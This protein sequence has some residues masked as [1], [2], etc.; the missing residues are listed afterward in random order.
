M[1][2]VADMSVGLNLTYQSQVSLSLANANVQ[3]T[4]R[5][6]LQSGVAVGTADK[7]YQA[8]RTITASSNDDLDL[9]GTT[10]IDSF[11]TAFAVVK[12][13]G[14]IISAA[15]ANTNNVILGGGASNPIT[16]LM[17]GTTPALIIR[18]GCTFALITGQADAT[19]YAVTA[20]TADI[21]RLTNS[22]A[23][24]SVTYD[25]VVVGTST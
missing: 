8:T 6:L 19:A 1:P 23:G 24:T 21:L 11:G 15:A 3:K 5:T 18:P 13:K 14:L 25:I 22:G 12:I 9:N 4:Y 10:V 17:T 7:L 16:S 2:L 20:A